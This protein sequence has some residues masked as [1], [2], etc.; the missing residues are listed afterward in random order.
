LVIGE[1]LFPHQEI[2]KLTWCSPYGRDKNQIGHLMIHVTLRTRSLQDV[3]VR[4][5]AGSYRHL[6]MATLKM[7]QRKN[8]RGKAR[9][10]QFDVDK[11]KKPRAKSNFTFLLK[12]KFQSLTDAEETYTAWHT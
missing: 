11:L 6:F 10:Q 1:T 2:H 12:N 8:G 4:G 5:G 9:E 7:K 3:R